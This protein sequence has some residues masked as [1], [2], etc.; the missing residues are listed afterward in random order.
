MICCKNVG[1]VVEIFRMFFNWGRFEK[2]DYLVPFFW[3]YLMRLIFFIR[4]YGLSRFSIPTAQNL[5]PI[6]VES[7]EERGLATKAGLVLINITNVA[8]SKKITT[9][10]N[11]HLYKW[12]ARWPSLA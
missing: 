9:L 12:A 7:P 10:L 1:F 6:A 11:S 4:K 5:A 3:F 8:A 2:E